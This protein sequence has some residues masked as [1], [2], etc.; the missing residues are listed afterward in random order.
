MSNIL[1]TAKRIHFIGIG[2]IGISAIARMM[3]A[4]G[5]VVSGSDR[6]QSKVTDELGKLSI[7]ITIGQEAGNIPE[8][9][10]LVVYTHALGQDN[11]ELVE[12]K[13]RS[14]PLLTYPQT[15]DLISKEKYTIAIS[16]THGKTTTT[17]MVAKVLI[18][19]GL[20]PTVIVGSLMKNPDGTESN[21][22]AGK[23][24]Y[25]VVEADEYK[26]SFHNLHPK[27]LVI[28]NI[29]EDHLDFYKDLADIQDS[30]KEVALKVPADGFIIADPKNPHVTPVLEDL[31]GKI[32]DFTPYIQSDLTLKVPGKHNKS[33]AGVALAIADVLKIDRN[34]ALKS[35]QEFGGLWRRF[36]FK[37][38]TKG[39]AEVYDDYAHNPQKVLA[40]LEG[41]REM[42]PD[43]KIIAVYQPHLYSR[44]KTLFNEFTKAFDEADMT[45]FIPI[46]PAREPFDA[47]ISSDMLA[48]AIQKRLGENRA[49]S[50]ATFE[51]A[52]RF[53]NEECN[54]AD[55]VVI[56]M[57]AG[58]GYKIGETFLQGD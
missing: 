47:T 2:G 52:E 27:I 58:D 19:A 12:A 5:K 13:K 41:A 25:L 44:T 33:N 37:G 51:E 35:L 10:D 3:Q 22:R 49:K 34:E 16:G 42:F 29:D 54:T 28:N 55:H 57:G 30:F 14:I 23:S 21:F 40:T 31:P 46:Y 24:R 43:K 7:K 50:V 9:C 32:I 38:K 53:L 15:L 17:A 4:E 56:T 48:E 26:K 20:D 36:E 18:D 6:D 45:L 39:G 1:E 8:E 11:L